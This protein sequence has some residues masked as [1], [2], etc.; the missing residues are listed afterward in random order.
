MDQPLLI[1]VGEAARLIGVSRTTMYEL[2]NGG[3]IPVVRL[4]GSIRINRQALLEQIER[5]TLRPAGSAA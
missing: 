5:E 1:R 3:R 4:G 2:I